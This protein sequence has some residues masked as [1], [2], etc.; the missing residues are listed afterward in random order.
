L[1]NFVIKRGRKTSIQEEGIGG[2]S[3]EVGKKKI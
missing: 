2:I 3:K 1:G